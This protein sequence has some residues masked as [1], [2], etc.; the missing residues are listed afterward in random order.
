MPVQRYRRVEDVPPPEALDPSDPVA[1]EGVWNLLRFATHEL[2]PAFAPG[3]RRYPSLEAADADR[4]A[5]E[6][7]RMRRLRARAAG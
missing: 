3:I 1:M 5:A 7:E 2:P 4:R 6:V